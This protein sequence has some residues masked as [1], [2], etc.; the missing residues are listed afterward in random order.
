MAGLKTTLKLSQ[1]L[2]MS[3]RLQQAIQLLQLNRQEL[4]AQI[5][6]ELLENPILEEFLETKENDPA[7]SSSDKMEEG[8]PSLLSEAGSDWDWETYYN[9]TSK[10]PPN[11]QS[12]TASAN[13]ISRY[14]SVLGQALS[15]ADHLV[16]QLNLSILGEKENE[17]GHII[18]DS[19]GDDGYLI[20]S[21]EELSKENPYSAEDFEKVL[22]TIQAFDPVGVGARSLKE[23]LKIQAQF[24]EE[25]N[26]DVMY[27]LDN[28]LKALEQKN[29]KVIANN[30][31]KD[32]EEVKELCNAIYAMD[33][34]PGLAYSNQRP[35][36]IVPDVYVYK[37]GSGYMIAL[38]EDGLP[39]LR[40]SN[41][42][43]N[44]LKTDQLD[45]AADDE[46]AKKYIESK[47]RSA[48]WLIRS[49]NQR[50]KTIYR[51]AESLL[52]YQKDFFDKGVEAIKPLILKTVANDL[53]V[54]ESTVSRITNNKYIDT[55]HGI[56][57]LKYFFN[58]GVSR[59][60][61]SI[62]AT[63]AIKLKVQNLIKNESP[64]KPLSD[65]K[66]V[67][68]LKKEVGIEIARR[69]VAKYREVLKILPAS[70]R[71]KIV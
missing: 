49:V 65:Q 39:R 51:V 19:I 17:I 44:L 60:D 48:L 20:C 46:Q 7:Q 28:F 66:I 69:T 36:Y 18:I 26:S 16:W 3:Q 1:Q 61:G 9:D 25:N 71:K 64:L 14:E 37:V 23:C 41:Y 68:I 12:S 10:L 38:N 47:I 6:K 59:K 13:D 27:I 53:Q 31:K 57:E 62:L 52:K 2:R 33:P 55:P 43:R 8:A 29:F 67:N 22:K 54:H 32:L 42:Y 58:S 35:E 4:S 70:K 45:K 30:M 11:F 63:E 56:Y 5:Q 50:N 34:K 24:I 40:I 21:L 15:L